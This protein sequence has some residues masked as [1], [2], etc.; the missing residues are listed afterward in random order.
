MSR[1]VRSEMPCV[2]PL[3]TCLPQSSYRS[4]LTRSH[5]N[6]REVADLD[7]MQVTAMTLKDNPFEALQ[8]VAPK[9]DAPES[10]QTA[11]EPTENAPEPAPQTEVSG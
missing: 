6:R 3:S 11:P 8:P 10:A 1:S 4:E 7:K 9:Q 5:P 2:E